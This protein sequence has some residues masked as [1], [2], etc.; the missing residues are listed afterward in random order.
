MSVLQDA[1]AGADKLVMDA[2]AL[3]VVEQRAEADQK[4]KAA[5]RGRIAAAENLQRLAHEFAAALHLYG[6]SAEDVTAA[7][8]LGRVPA[9]HELEALR[10]PRL[11]VWTLPADVQQCIIQ[12][13]SVNVIVDLPARE[14][15]TWGSV[16]A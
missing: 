13:G 15:A 16:L 11:G 7:W 5:V 8:N 10:N 1:L 3:A 12:T 4:F 14:R 2:E 9:S 6:A